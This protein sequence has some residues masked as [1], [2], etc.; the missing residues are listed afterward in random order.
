MMNFNVSK[1]IY[2]YYQ[3]D[4]YKVELDHHLQGIISWLWP[5]LLELEWIIDPCSVH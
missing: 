5:D 2:Q 4:D 1:W 3:N